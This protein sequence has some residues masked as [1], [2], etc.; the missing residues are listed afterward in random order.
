MDLKHNVMQ[1]ADPTELIRSVE[2]E[3]K[4][5]FQGEGSGHDWW[6]IYR[7]Y[8][9]AQRIAKAEGA[10]VHITSL[11]ALLHDIADHKFHG[12]DLTVGALE[13]DRLLRA[14]RADDATIERV[15]R[16]VNEVTFKGAGVETPVS[17]LEAACVQDADRL[18]AIGAVGIARAFAY[19]GAK[20]RLLFDPDCPPVWHDSFEA[21][22]GDKGATI[23]HFH[24]KLLLLKDR[25]QTNT[26]R[27]IAL[28][29]HRFMEEYMTQF[30]HEWEG[31]DA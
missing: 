11:G 1:A 13:T 29:R 27:Q 19:G 23:N 10:D 16:I 6:H 3:V 18:D 20:G 2:R 24:E 17:S 30:H 15:V 8:Q 12:G 5:R 25:M 7:V 22:A 21:Y 26:G 28:S 31:D 9:M 14:N 4:E